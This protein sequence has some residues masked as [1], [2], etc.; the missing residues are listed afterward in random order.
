MYITCRAV[1]D[2]IKDM[3]AIWNVSAF[4]IEANADRN[5]KEPSLVQGAYG[6]FCDEVWISVAFEVIVQT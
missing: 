1:P 5:Y 6:L 4:S 3:L 2:R